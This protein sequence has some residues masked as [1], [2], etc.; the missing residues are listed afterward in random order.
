M[1]HFLGSCLNSWAT[2]SQNSMALSTTEDE[3][4]ATT[5]YSTQ[6]LQ[7][8]QQLKDF[9]LNIEIVPISA[10]TQVKTNIA[11]NPAQHKRTKHIDIRHYFLR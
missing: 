5:S 4:V 8:K 10:I 11:K 7:I 1:T 6:L 9:V 3:Y 2:K